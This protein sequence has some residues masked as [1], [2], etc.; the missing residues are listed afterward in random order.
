MAQPEAPA[1]HRVG[2]LER[3][4]A[5]LQA[6]GV[7]NPVLPEGAE[8]PAPERI[9]RAVEVMRFRPGGEH[10]A[11]NPVALDHHAVAVDL[12]APAA[13]TTATGSFPSCPDRTMVP[14]IDSVIPS[15]AR[16]LA[17]PVDVR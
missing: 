6:A 2:R 14:G 12:T 13:A 7:E 17:L 1:E 16:I 9:E 8:L 11:E 5:L 15:A 3:D 4:Q 10:H